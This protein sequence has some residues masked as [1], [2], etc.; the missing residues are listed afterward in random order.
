MAIDLF[1]GLTPGP[2]TVSNFG[3]I[4]SFG[5]TPA[6]I[7]ISTGEVTNGGGT[8][9]SAL[10]EGASGVVCLLPDGGV[11]TIRNSGTIEALGGVGVYGVSMGEGPFANGSVN[12]STALIEGYG[13][14]SFNG[15]GAATNF[16]TIWS[17]GDAGGAGVRLGGG[18][19]LTNGGASHKGAMIEGYVG[20]SV[21]SAGVVANFGT[22]V[23]EGG[24]AVVFG[25]ASDLLY[26]EA[27]SVFIGSVNGDGGTLDLAS[28]V[29]TVTG[30]VSSKSVTVSGSMAATAFADFNTV[31][32]APGASFTMS[33]AADIAAGQSV[34]DSGTLTINA[35]VGH[36]HQCR[37]PWRRRRRDLVIDSAVDNTGVLVAFGGTLTVDGAVTGAG[38]CTSAAG[39]PTSL[40]P[41]AE[42]VAFT[43]TTGVL[44]LSHSQTYTGEVTGFSK[45]GTT[46]L[47]LVDIDFISGTT[48]ATFAGSATSGVLTVT[49][50]TH[51]AKITLE[52]D[53][54]GSTFKVS[55][56]GHGGT[57][58][59]D[60][61]KPAAPHFGPAPR[62]HPFIAAAASFGASAGSMSLAETWRSS[63]PRWPGPGRR[64][65]SGR[66][67]PNLWRV[68][69]PARRQ[70]R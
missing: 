8:D 46:S 66:R 47:D 56:D 44:E 13:G 5:A 43:G 3:T 34:I 65:P 40:R 11:D 2:S 36:H 37:E 24:K 19:S 7:Y 1:G 27:D 64:P 52:G 23:G 45:T 26:V 70:R 67:P 62:A 61:T 41:S 21:I 22:I 9:R 68:R 4:E 55:S 57:T 31:R 58:V 16:G 30:L 10:I 35:G 54:V 29:G 28:G 20:V 32:V 15:T 42:N 18:G 33:G 48:K 38:R 63:R 25:S 17:Q 53:Y 60:P 50:G 14:L 12:N 39:Q 69:Q 59:V 49:D 51:T 6:G